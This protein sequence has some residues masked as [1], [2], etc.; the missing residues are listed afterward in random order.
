MGTLKQYRFAI[1]SLVLVGL[2]L[3]AYFGILRE[4]V[5]DACNGRPSDWMQTLLHAFYPRF[6][7][8]QHRFEPAFFIAK[9]D[10]VIYRLIGVIV[11]IGGFGQVVS[12]DSKRI[13]SFLISPSSK[14]IVSI[15]TGVLVFIQCLI[16]FEFW[17][18]GIERQALAEFYKPNWLNG[19]IGNVFPDK[20][21]FTLLAG[22]W[23]ALIFLNLIK[24]LRII[25][26]VLC[27]G[28]FLWMQGYYFGFE[29]ID[30]SFYT[31][32]LVMLLIPFY[33]Y[34]N[35]NE[36]VSKSW[37]LRWI[38]ILVA[39]VYGISAVEKLSISG[40]AW[41]DAW[42]FQVH[43]YQHPTT[44]GLWLAKYDGLC[45]LM[46]LG[47]LL[48]QLAFPIGLFKRTWMPWIC[49]TG[50]VFHI[51]TWLLMDIGHWLNPWILVYMVFYPQ[52]SRLNTH[53]QD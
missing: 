26:A 27:I 25:S 3:T 2:V 38:Q 19:I 7:V 32:F 52:F 41:L 8:E 22:L 21:Q 6:L 33:Q 45:S 49:L 24:K 5:V 30:H 1:I 34:E 36:Y 48:I 29:K 50:A 37:S 40:W 10:M 35:R 51:S 17:Q 20:T 11:L 46:L 42:N 13:A 14:K 16:L 43:L 47:S 39:L 15:V 28:F 44:L 31:F 4:A 9:A 12:K 23:A 53:N 18:T